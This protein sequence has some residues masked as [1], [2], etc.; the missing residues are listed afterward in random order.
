VDAIPN[1]LPL[2]LRDFTPP[3]IVLTAPRLVS[4]GSTSSTFPVQFSVTDPRG[5]GVADWDLHSM[6]VGFGSW[7]VAAS[8]SSGGNQSVP[9]DGEEGAT[10]DL[11][12]TATDEQGN[13]REGPMRRV[14]VPYDDDTVPGLVISGTVGSQADATAYGGTLS[15]LSDTDSSYSFF[16]G[17]PQ[18][19][20]S[21]WLIGPGTGDWTIRISWNV[22]QEATVSAADIPDGPRK[23]L[24]TTSSCGFQ[25][26]VELV[27]GASVAIDAIG[28]AVE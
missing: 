23:V 10:Y 24:W 22:T 3:K 26:T 17:S 19:C 11:Y 21:I 9:F 6:H 13:E 2:P 7:E 1:T 14:I 18:D 15:V 16:A 27:S 25:Y 28:D 5:S 4:T 8:G 12:V 20:P